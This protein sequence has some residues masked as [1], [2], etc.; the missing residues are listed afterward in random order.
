MGEHLGE[1]TPDTVQMSLQ[2]SRSI[3]IVFTILTTA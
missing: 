1:L 3:V 2:V